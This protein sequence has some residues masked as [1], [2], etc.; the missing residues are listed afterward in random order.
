MKYIL[1]VLSFLFVS[2][3][4]AAEVDTK[5]S[6]F[7]WYASKVTGDHYGKVMLVESMLI[8]KDGKVVGGE[9]IMDMTT[10]TVENID[11][12]KYEK[13]FLN[14]MKSDDFFDVAKY[15]TATLKINKIEGTNVEG[16]LTIKNKTNPINFTMEQNGDLVTGKMKFDRTKYDM[17][18]NSENFF[19]DLGDKMIHD[20]VV[21]TFN[22]KIVES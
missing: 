10:F 22:V 21:I 13:K 12:P 15:P 19:K 1:I 3:A 6:E 14:H 16:D 11:S 8:E 5:N 17:I 7:D 2:I 4:G 18:Y 20:K 9:F